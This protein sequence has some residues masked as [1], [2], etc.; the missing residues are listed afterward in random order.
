MSNRFDTLKE[1]LMHESAAILLF[2]TLPMS[3]LLNC[4]FLYE[5]KP[6][7]SFARWNVFERDSSP[8]AKSPLIDL[9]FTRGKIWLDITTEE[10]RSVVE[11]LVDILPEYRT[12]VSIDLTKPLLSWTTLR[13]PEIYG[14]SN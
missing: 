11:P 9:D 10:G 1:A 7:E 14:F 8:T 4:F 3:K 5:K 13:V 2:D 6:F 12:P